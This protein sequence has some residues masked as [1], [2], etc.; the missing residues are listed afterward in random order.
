M[1]TRPLGDQV[2]LYSVSR[3]LPTDPKKSAGEDNTNAKKYGE[4]QLITLSDRS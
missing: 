3:I 2:R 1:R 4:V